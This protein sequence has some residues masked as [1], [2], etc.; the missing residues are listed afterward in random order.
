MLN[1]SLNKISI[2]SLLFTL[3]QPPE[4]ATQMPMGEMTVGEAT[5]SEPEH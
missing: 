3:L 2:L 5:D 1:L 4:L